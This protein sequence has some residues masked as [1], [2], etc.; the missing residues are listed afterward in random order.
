MN[1][2]MKTNNDLELLKKH[3]QEKKRF[4]IY[5]DG[6]DLGIDYDEY[7]ETD[8]YYH[9]HFKDKNGNEHIIGR[10]SIEDILRA[11]VDENYYIKVKI[12]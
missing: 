1:L 9:G 12:A 7:D 3:L 2:V 5:Y 10:L 11:I 4:K 8:G 6:D